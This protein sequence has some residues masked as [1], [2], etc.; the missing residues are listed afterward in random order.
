MNYV[1]ILLV[2]FIGFLCFLLGRISMINQARRIKYQSEI[3][4]ENSEIVLVEADKELNR[5]LNENSQLRKELRNAL[6][7]GRRF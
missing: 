5:L 4:L 7:P 2:S 3:Q 6:S 1:Q